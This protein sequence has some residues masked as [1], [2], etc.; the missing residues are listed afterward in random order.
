M[1]L[2]FAFFRAAIAAGAFMSGIPCSS[3]QRV[4]SVNRTISFWLIRRRRW[5]WRDK[6]ANSLCGGA[7]VILRLMLAE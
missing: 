4:F 1:Q 2:G 3:N 7:C 5:L 6:S